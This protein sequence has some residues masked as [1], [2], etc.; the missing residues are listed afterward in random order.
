MAVMAYDCLGIIAIDSVPFGSSVTGDY[1]AKFLRRKLGP[2]A[3]VDS[4]GVDTPRHYKTSWTAK[5][6]DCLHQIRAGSTA[7]PLI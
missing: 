1:Y 4:W 6:K 3:A 7:S 2:T 5:H